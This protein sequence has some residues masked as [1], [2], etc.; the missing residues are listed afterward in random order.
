ME[1]DEWGWVCKAGKVTN[2]EKAFIASSWS[3]KERKNPLYFWVSKRAFSHQFYLNV[4]C[5]LLDARPELF[6]VAH[7]TDKPDQILGW[8][9]VGP[10]VTHL[11]FKFT[12]LYQ[13]YVKE[14]FR[15]YGLGEMLSDKCIPANPKEFMELIND[16]RKTAN[17]AN[18]VSHK[19]EH[20]RQDIQATT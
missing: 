16:S 12:T 17:Q 5:F 15:A 20:I 2:Q 1:L 3:H 19:P 11:T 6:H 7:N 9:C 4:I 10:I 8:R 14:D 13:S 18:R